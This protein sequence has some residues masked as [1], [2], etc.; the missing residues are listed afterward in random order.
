MIPAKHG[1][2]LYELP[3]EGL[4]DAERNASVQFITMPLFPTSI[5][6]GAIPFH[7]TMVVTINR[8]NLNKVLAQ[9]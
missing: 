1:G 5:D 9:R 6:S 3:G 2:L 4:L 8:R 7:L